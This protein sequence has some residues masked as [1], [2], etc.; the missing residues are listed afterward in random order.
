MTSLIVL[1]AYLSWI[2]SE[3]LVLRS[4]SGR[5]LLNAGLLFVASFVLATTWWRL[6][7][8]GFRQDLMSRTEEYFFGELQD[9]GF[10]LVVIPLLVLCSGLWVW[11]RK[12]TS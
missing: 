12:S 11:I 2:L 8:H 9:M 1:I 3:R 10:V 7:G 4:L 5:S 6:T